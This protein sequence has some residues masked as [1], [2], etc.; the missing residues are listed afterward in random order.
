MKLSESTLAGASN[1]VVRLRLFID[2]DLAPVVDAL[3]D[4]EISTWVHQIPWPYSVE[5]G[6]AFFA[7]AADEWERA[8]GAHLAIE[9]VPCSGLA[10]S[11][12]LTAVNHAYRTAWVG[13][14]IAEHHRGRGLATEAVAAIV[15]WAFESLGLERLSLMTD[16]DNAR[17]RNV[18]RKNGFVE[19]GRLRSALRT[20][21][22]TR[23]DAIL[24]SLLPTDL[25]E[26]AT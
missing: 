3:Q 24:Y 10:G 21:D 17:S 2:A 26:R 19:E 18:A 14:W 20:K 16:P 6:R 23:R 22:G 13:Y 12:G 15:R 1:E 7:L 9:H 11:V 8:A 4:P 5:D 25:K